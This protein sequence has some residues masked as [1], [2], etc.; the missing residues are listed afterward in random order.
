MVDR[1]QTTTPLG[2]NRRLPILQRQRNDAAR[3]RMQRRSSD[4]LARQVYQSI[5]HSADKARPT[6]RRVM[7]ISDLRLNQQDG[8]GQ[9]KLPHSFTPITP[10]LLEAQETI[11][12]LHV[13]QGRIHNDLW[14][15]LRPGKGAK[16]GVTAIKALWIFASIMWRRRNRKKHGRTHKEKTYIQKTLLD[17]EITAFREKLC[18][19]KIPHTPVPIGYRHR[20]DAKLLWLRCEKSALQLWEQ[21]KLHSYITFHNTH[22]DTNHTNTNEKSHVMADEMSNRRF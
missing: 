4:R 12:W 19:L 10:D 5:S 16:M 18:Q 3:V 17:V 1:G 14:A 6:E 7:D 15:Y 2:Q 22:N 11:G 13:H 20:V 8:G 21:G 9:F